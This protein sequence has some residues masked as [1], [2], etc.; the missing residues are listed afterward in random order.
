MFV[1]GPPRSLRH[2]T[3]HSSFLGDGKACRPVALLSRWHLLR[4]ERTQMTLWQKVPT[5]DSP[6]PKLGSVCFFRCGGTG[7]PA[8]FFLTH[9]P[10]PHNVLVGGRIA[11]DLLSAMLTTSDGRTCQQQS[12]IGNLGKFMRHTL[13]FFSMSPMGDLWGGSVLSVPSK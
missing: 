7:L 11:I 8:A 12:C 1:A 10:F 4:A 5:G 3:D 9:G 2:L 13:N 6:G